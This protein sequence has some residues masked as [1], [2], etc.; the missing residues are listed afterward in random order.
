MTTTKRVVAVV[1]WVYV[2]R[3][4]IL[5][6]LRKKT[7]AAW[8]TYHYLQCWRVAKGGLTGGRAETRFDLVDFEQ[9]SDLLLGW[10]EST[11]GK[12]RCCCNGSRIK[13]LARQNL[14]TLM[15]SLI[16]QKERPLKKH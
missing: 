11:S 8:L 13:N 14:K 15:V 1:E 7:S 6:P 5:G 12:V 3:R 16:R 4:R 9:R 2:G 10:C